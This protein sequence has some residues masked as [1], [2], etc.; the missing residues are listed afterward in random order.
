MTQVNKNGVYSKSIYV[1][2]N[3]TFKDKQSNETTLGLY[4]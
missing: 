2:L 4:I 3:S 1:G